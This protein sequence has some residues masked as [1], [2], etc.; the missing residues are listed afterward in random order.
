MLSGIWKVP[1]SAPETNRLPAPS[2]TIAVSAGASD[3]GSLIV[4]TKPLVG[5]IVLTRMADSRGPGGRGSSAPVAAESPPVAS[6]A[7]ASAEKEQHGALR[8]VLNSRYLL[9]IAAQIEG[10]VAVLRLADPGSPTL[11]QDKDNKGA[12][13]VLMPMRV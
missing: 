10:E 8:L 11:V 6:T 5:S 9:D 1:V 2:A 12:L 4:V 13:Y 7:A 3:P